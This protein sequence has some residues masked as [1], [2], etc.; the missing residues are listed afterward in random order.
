MKVTEI[1]KVDRETM[2]EHL[3]GSEFSDIE[4]NFEER[5]Q[6]IILDGYKGLSQYTNDELLEA[7]RDYIS[8]DPE[9]PLIIEMEAT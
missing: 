7:Y 8:E 9:Y 6:A 5:I 4:A 3:S 1:I 2:I